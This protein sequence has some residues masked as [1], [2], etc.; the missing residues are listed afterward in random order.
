MTISVSTFSF[1][2]SMA[3]LACSTHCHSMARHDLRGGFDI[4][5]CTIGASS[6]HLHP[7]FSMLRR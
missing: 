7:F 6:L 3:A 2:A 1:S 5:S 4:L